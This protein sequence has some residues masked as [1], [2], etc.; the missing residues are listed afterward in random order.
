[1]NE[2]IKQFEE[3]FDDSEVNL[4]SLNTF[5]RDVKG[6]DSLIFLSLMAMVEEEYSVRLK[7]EELR[8]CNTIEDIW[9][10]IDSKRNQQ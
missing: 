8:S 2:F 7:A 9:K 6:W 1:M 4:L 5:F 10:I 3:L